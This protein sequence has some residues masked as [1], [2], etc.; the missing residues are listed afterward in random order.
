MQLA[1]LTG[2]GQKSVFFQFPFRRDWPCNTRPT[3]GEPCCRAHHFQF[4]FRRDW[5]CN[6][7]ELDATFKI[8]DLSVPFSS[9]LALQP[10]WNA[11]T[12]SGRLIFQ[13]PFRRDW[14]CNHLDLYRFLLPRRAFS[15][16]FV[17]IGL[18]TIVVI[19]NH[20]ADQL[21]QFPF[22]RDWPCNARSRNATSR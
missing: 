10:S 22:R 7:L 19:L 4:P 21:F 8:A 2:G 14:P 11:T 6:K 17:G 15:S 3:W 20:A 1:K 12:T 5:P 16:L 13:F 9:G 18:A